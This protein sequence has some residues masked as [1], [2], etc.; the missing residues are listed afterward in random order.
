VPLVLLV[1]FATGAV[2]T[3]PVANCHPVSTTLM[4]N[5]QIWQIM[6]TISEYLNLKVNSKEKFIFLL[7]VLPNGVQTP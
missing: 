3:T 4:V 1:L 7:T 2:S 6:G 5:S